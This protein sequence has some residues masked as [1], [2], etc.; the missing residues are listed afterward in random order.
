MAKKDAGGDK[1]AAS[2]PTPGKRHRVSKGERR[3]VSRRT[4][5]MCRRSRTE[6]DTLALQLAAW[7]RGLPV[8]DFG[9]PVYNSTVAKGS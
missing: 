7:W 9:K 8:R 5:K 6:G 1:P 4:V 3:S 2:N